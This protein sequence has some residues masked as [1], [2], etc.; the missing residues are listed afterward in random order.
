MRRKPEPG[1]TRFS[2]RPSDSR[3]S[4]VDIRNVAAIVSAADSER[5]RALNVQSVLGLRERIARE[6]AS[7]GLDEKRLADLLGGS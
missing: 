1:S 6:A 2:T 5:L 3:S 7:S 4:F